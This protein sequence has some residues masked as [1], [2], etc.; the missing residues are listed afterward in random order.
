[1]KNCFNQQDPR[2]NGEHRFFNDIKD[3]IEV[4]F[5][6]GCRFDSAFTDF[7]GE[8][9]YFE[10]VGDFLNRLKTQP[11]RNTRSFFNNFGL[12]DANGQF[13][14]YPRFQSFYNRVDSCKI[15]DSNNKIVLQ[16]VKAK[17]YIEKYN[18]GRID[19]LKI[20]T[21]G[22]EFAVIK[23]FEDHIQKVRYIQF[24]Y[25]GTFIDTKVKLVDVVNYLRDRGFERFS[26]LSRDGLVEI[27][28]FTDH[29]QYCN[30]VCF[31]SI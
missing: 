19:F 16:L 30:I 28:D 15:D 4:I 29:Y 23:G 18:I 12:S 20:D 25:G 14:Y 11:N 31:N 10:P 24:E 22:S 1:M 17:D 26:Y 5:D 21:E 13:S 7:A 6:V 3:K 8:V 2:T 9:H 27:T